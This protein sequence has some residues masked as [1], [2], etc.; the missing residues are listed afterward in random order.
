M[1]KPLRIFLFIASGLLALLLFI[2]VALLLFVDADAYRPR[3][4]TGAS[5]VL[6]MDV[7][8]SGQ[9]GIDFFP[10][11]HITL[12]DV[13]IGNQ[14]ID[15]ATV[16]E[17]RVSIDLL[18]LLK[19]QVRFGSIAL[20][21]PRISIERDR[22]GNFNFEKPKPAGGTLPPLDLPKISLS[23]GTLR[24][25]DQ[26]S[27]E[28]FEALGCSLKVDHLRFARGK[29]SDLMKGLSFTAQLACEE[30]RKSGFTVSDLQVS[31][32]GT[33]GVVDLQP[34]TMGVFGAK[35]SG[36][37]RADFS[38][39][40]P[41]YDLRYALPRF[42]IEEFCKPLSQQKVAEGSMDFFANLSMRG[43]TVNQLR[44]TLAGEISLQGKSLRL[45][46]RDLDQELS[47]FES[48]QNFN[49]VDVGAFFFA[50]PL[51]LVVTK[52]H[53]FASIFQGSGGRSE[54]RTLVSDWKV[55]GGVAQAQDVAMAT[56]EHRIALQGGLDFVHQQFD[57]VTVALIDAE[58]CT[59]VRQS[60]QGDFRN[61]VVE[62]PSVL[63]TLAGPVRKLFQMG[64]DLFPGGECE[65]FYT[66][67]V[68]PPK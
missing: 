12:G 32:A 62:Q 25:M 3:L 68:A 26:P 18:P 64:R 58:G 41:R 19:K 13:H 46:G 56:N 33:N 59:K 48:S 44:Q 35:G 30:V 5:Q 55:E 10:G 63:K 1:S 47:Q 23:E 50:G 66:G 60:I 65:V 20:E 11:L 28:G 52:G 7:R 27:G 31:A 42:R 29:S 17:A 43:K 9:L 34:V 16:K 49:L 6:G 36:S 51:G 22:D 39:A 24:F 57:N 8:I 15:I 67:S 53:G 45:N 61:P 2:A 14:G 37:I 54:I 40:A 21:H 38:G 4:E